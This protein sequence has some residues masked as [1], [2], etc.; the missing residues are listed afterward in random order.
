MLGT[1]I[2]PSS[3]SSANKNVKKN[4]FDNLITGKFKNKIIPINLRFFNSNF[5]IF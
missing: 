4:N 3:V 5:T 1:E 2:D